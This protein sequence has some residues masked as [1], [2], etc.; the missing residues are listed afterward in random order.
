MTPL[1]GQ[2]ARVSDFVAQHIP[3]CER[4][5]SASSKAI[6]VLDG[7]KLIAGMVYHNWAPE[8]GVM[9]LSG[10]SID[11]RWLQRPILH[12]IF[13]YPFTD[14][15]CQMVVMR[16]SELNTSLH[17]I[18]RGLQFDEYRIPRLRGRDE[19][20]IIFTLTVENWQSHQKF[21]KVQHG[22]I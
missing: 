15:G 19:D 2:D 18:L 13:D 17:R 3:G 6:G 21:T 22:K 9:E 16:V 7:E 1:Y 8:A 20:E 14:V 4:G 10:A 11:R 5:F 12:A